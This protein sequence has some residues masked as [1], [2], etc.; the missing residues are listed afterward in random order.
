MKGTKSEL[1]AGVDTTPPCVGLASD[2]DDDAALGARIVTVELPLLAVTPPLV[3]PEPLFKKPRMSPVVA[4]EG[5]RKAPP[6][7]PLGPAEGLRRTSPVLFVFPRLVGLVLTPLDPATGL[8]GLPKKP[9]IS[10][11]LGAGGSILAFLAS[12]RCKHHK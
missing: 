4:A 12:V 8:L 6:A 2:D 10:R 11:L 3:E 9:R 1:A 5:F 7:T